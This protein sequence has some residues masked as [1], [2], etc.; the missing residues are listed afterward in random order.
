MGYII[1]EAFENQLEWFQSVDG[2]YQ[3]LMPDIDGIIRSQVFPGLWLAVEALL[4]NQMARVLEVMQVG[5]N[6]PEHSAFVE[7][8][9]Q[10]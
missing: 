10:G 2:D 5:L 9:K 6:S 4:N 8:L 7:Q 1:W 3:Q